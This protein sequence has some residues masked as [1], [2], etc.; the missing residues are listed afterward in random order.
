MNI[1]NFLRSSPDGRSGNRN[2][3]YWAVN[4]AALLLWCF[5]LG[6]VCLYFAAAPTPQWSALLISYVKA[7]MLFVLNMLPPFLIAGMCWMA[8]G[9]IWAA[10][11]G[12][13]LVMLGTSFVNFYKIALRNDPF[14]AADVLLIS[15]AA[16]ISEGYTFDITAAVVLSIIAAVAAV[17]FSAYL[18]RAKPDWRVRVAVLLVL[19][20]MSGWLVSN[21]YFDDDLYTELE[22][23]DRNAWFM[24]RWSDRDQ[25]ISRGFIYPFIHSAKTAVEKAPDGYD[26]GESAAYLAA[27][28]DSDIPEDKKVNIIAIMLEAYNDFSKFGTL[29]F[30]TDPYEYFHSLQS[31]ALHGELVTNI[32]A[33]GTI[34]TE[35]S[36][37]TGYS[38]MSQYRGSLPTYVSYLKDQG[39]YAEGGHPGFDWFYN[40]RNVAEY[41]GFD[42]YWFREDRYAMEGDAIMNDPEFFADLLELYRSHNE[43]RGDPYFSFS[44]TY[45]NHGPYADTF[46]Y[47]GEHVYAKNLGYS[48]EAYRILNNYLWGINLTDSALRDLI[49]PLRGDDEPVVVVLFGDHNPWLG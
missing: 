25:Y 1:I 31:E 38:F 13:G 20:L 26:K 11:L 29:E 39:Y 49:E 21:V 30:G 34:D 23:I 19:A 32:F 44:V 36:F 8:F 12:S 22:N 18:L 27:F 5:G 14:L 24:S 47:D 48:D 3:A 17:V 9:R 40:R 15:E 2:I 45:Q 37:V 7:P 46:L 35:R 16:N 33:G 43:S 28:E 6:L 4:I 42:N 41:F 10:I